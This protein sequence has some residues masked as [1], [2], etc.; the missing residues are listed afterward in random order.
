MATSIR[1]PFVA[2][3]FYPGTAQEIKDL[4]E[5]IR[6]TEFSSINYTLANK[7][8]YGAIL[9]HAGHLYSGSET[10]HF[11]EILN[12]TKQVFDSFVILH[13]IHRGVAPEYACD[14]SERW[15]TPLGEISL[16]ME[17]IEKSG[18]PVSS[19][20]QKWEHSAEVILPFIQHFIPYS[21][22]IVPVGISHQTP[23]IAEIIS[24]CLVNAAKTTGRNICII[25]S[26]DFTHYVD[27]EKGKCMDEKVLEKIK[28]ND[29]EGIYR[30]IKNNNI[31]VCGC[32]PIMTIIYCLKQMHNE[33]KTTILRRG[34]SGEVN[35][36]ESVVDYI[37][38]LFHS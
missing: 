29:P 3:R 5:K 10:I 9:P 24:R 22:K 17:F 18:I 13:P 37:S 1:H 11:F 32:G 34:N 2:G 26:S 14:A 38:I 8:I 30:V 31:T 21:F 23:E 12:R 4:I 19:E 20:Q 35:P 36:S 25:A 28:N 6:A 27:P 15:S 33:F 7:M 16:D